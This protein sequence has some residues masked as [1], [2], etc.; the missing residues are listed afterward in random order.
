MIKRQLLFFAIAA[1][2]A[3]A[4]ALRFRHALYLVALLP[5]GLIA[6]WAASP[7]SWP[8]WVVRGLLRTLP[9]SAA[10]GLVLWLSR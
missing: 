10:L 1:L 2:P 6:W 4:F 8:A 9:A 3:V 5:A 7:V